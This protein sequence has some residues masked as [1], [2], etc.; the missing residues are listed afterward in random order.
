MQI[1]SKCDNLL[2]VTGEDG[3]KGNARESQSGEIE[4]AIRG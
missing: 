2:A 4:D 1:R 3:M